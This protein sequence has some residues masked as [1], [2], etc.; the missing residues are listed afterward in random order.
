[1]SEILQWL[2][3]YSPGVV[4]L[5]ALGAA[6]VFVI[7]LIVEKSIESTFDARTKQLEKALERRSTFEE[8]V[9]S[10]RFSL[11]VAFSSRLERV[12][13]NL[14]R[15][16]SGQAAPEGLM[17]QN[18]IVP[19]TEI[20]E[21]LSVHRLVLGEVFHGLFL[22]QAQLALNVANTSSGEEWKALADEWTGTQQAIR[23]EVEAAF[24]ISGI[25]W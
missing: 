15:L 20:F 22:K 1:M 24:G 18:E 2:K 5:I 10:D 19:L 16:R 8:K 21:D 11:I 7:K 23:R 14:N 9:L 13:T 4:L 25:K 6:L 12:L 3:D 17:R